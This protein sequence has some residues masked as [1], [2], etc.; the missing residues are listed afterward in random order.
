[1]KRKILQENIVN[2]KPANSSLRPVVIS[3]KKLKNYYSGFS[4]TVLN[5]K[6]EK[7]LKRFK[8]YIFIDTLIENW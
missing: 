8:Y 5:L 2:I 4:L 3:G 6:R 7:A 1:V